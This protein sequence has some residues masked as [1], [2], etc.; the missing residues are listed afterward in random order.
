MKLLKVIGF[1]TVLLFTTKTF[2]NAEPSKK[3]DVRKEISNILSKIDLE[4]ETFMLNFI[5]NSKGEIVVVSTSSEKNDKI[6]RE[7]L[8]YKKVGTESVDIH[9]IYS[10]P[11]TI[12][13][14]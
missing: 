12:Q 2:A 3:L 8:N 14:K 10:V 6:V 1:A 9:T 11:V 4:S 5:V 7:T 13:N